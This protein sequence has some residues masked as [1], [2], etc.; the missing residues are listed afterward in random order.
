MWKY[1][2]IGEGHRTKNAKCKLVVTLGVRYRSRNRLLFTGTPLQNNLTE[3]WAL[4]NF[5]LPTIFSSSDTFEQLFQRLFETRTLGE[6]AELEEEETLLVIN[7]LAAMTLR[8]RRIRLSRPLRWRSH[9]TRNAFQISSR[10]YLF[11]I[12]ERCTKNEVGIRC[13]VQL[14]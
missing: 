14:R 3:L 4:L 6:T 7:R 13:E 9:G 10:Y 11:R 8:T 1:I 5:L 12:A 2:I